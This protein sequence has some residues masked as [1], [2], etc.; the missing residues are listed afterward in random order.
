MGEQQRPRRGGKATGAYAFG[1]TG[2]SQGPARQQIEKPDEQAI[3]EVIVGLRRDGLSYRAIA[4]ILN[5]E[6][7]RPRRADR[8]HP[9]TVRAVCLRHETP[10]QDKPSAV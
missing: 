4:A 6:C 2:E 1:Y 7:L 5:E 8:W 9:M 10:V 3:V